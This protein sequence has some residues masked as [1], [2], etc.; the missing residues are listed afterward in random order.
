MQKVLILLLVLAL[1]IG[2]AQESTSPPVIETDMSR[3]NPQARSIIEASLKSA[4]TISDWQELGK[5]LQAHGLYDAAIQ[6]YVYVLSK[7]H[8]SK[9]RYLLG[10]AYAHIGEY[11]NAINNCSQ[12]DNY[13]PAL[14]RKGFWLL[15]LGQYEEAMSVF[16]N[17]L[18]ID[19]TEAAAH[20]GVA[21]VHLAQENPE[22]AILVLE[23]ILNR[24]GRHQ[25]LLQLLGKAHQQ[26]G[27]PKI[28]DQLLRS[29]ISGQPKWNDPW[30]D[31]LFTYKRGFSAELIH[32]TTEIDSGNLQSAL[33]SLKVIEK[34]YP[35]SPEVQNNLATVQ[36]QLGMTSEA[37]N[38][39]G[40]A[41][42]KAPSY[43]PLKLTMAF[44]MEVV[45]DYDKAMESARMALD[46]Q[47]SMSIAARTIGTVALRQKE[48]LIAK[49]FLLHAIELGDNALRTR[50]ILGELHMRFGEVHDAIRQYLIVLQQAP[51]RTASIAGLSIA[52]A[53]KGDK[54][55]A[56]QLLNNALQQFPEDVNLLQAKRVLSQSGQT[57]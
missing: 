4:T 34:K 51:N 30:L 24:G 44:S 38:T 46:L 17:V 53:N 49:K 52:Y 22:E 29:T 21:R 27:H 11:E 19:S 3:V 28:A 43:A 55:K 7:T 41:I 45:G 36:L 20:I 25:Y 13:T 15:D 12:V 31:D 48:F 14:W 32:A 50:E 9:T 1:S 26:A 54:E 8:D 57:Q 37:I 23:N 6:S 35:F 18:S 2:C 42:Q 39:L 47:P 56:M 10:L 33:K 5:Y 40:R 16:Q